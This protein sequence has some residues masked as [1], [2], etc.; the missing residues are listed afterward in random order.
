MRTPTECGGWSDDEDADDETDVC[1]RHPLPSL[2]SDVQQL[3][4]KLKQLNRKAEASRLKTIK[5]QEEE[6]DDDEEE[7]ETTDIHPASG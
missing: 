3:K 1:N 6:D 2:S 5:E 7:Q 4:L